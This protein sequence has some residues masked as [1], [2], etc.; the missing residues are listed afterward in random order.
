MGLLNI[1]HNIGKFKKIV[2]I[3]PI[4]T[5]IWMII[6]T[7]RKSTKIY[8]M[9]TK[10]S[11][12][13]LMAIATPTHMVITNLEVTLETKGI[14]HSTFLINKKKKPKRVKSHISMLLPLIIGHTIPPTICLLKPHQWFK[15]NHLQLMLINLMLQRLLMEHQEIMHILEE[16][17]F[18]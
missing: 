4:L 5:K 17:I 7:L 1:C 2:K 8:L 9:D 3:C 15:G 12:R 11:A 14:S 6:N 16:Q 13:G 10:V 18:P